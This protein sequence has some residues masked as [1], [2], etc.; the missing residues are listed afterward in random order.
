MRSRAGMSRIEVLVAILLVAMASGLVLAAIG[1]VR[2]ASAQMSCRNK[3]RQLGIAVANAHDVKNRLPSLVDQGEAAETGKGLP[4]MF[5]IITPYLEQHPWNYYPGRTATEYYANSSVAFGYHNKDGAPGTLHGGIANESRVAFVCPSDI[6]A[7]RLRDVQMTLPDGTTGYYATGSYAANGLLR[8]GS[9][10]LSEM[11]GGIANTIMLAERPQVCTTASGETVYN[12]WGVGFYSPHMPAFATLTPTDPP[13]LWPTGQ[14]APAWPLP[15]EQA[16][17]GDNH[18][19]YRI[20]VRDAAVQSLEIAPFQ[21]LGKGQPC[22]PRLPGTM[23]KGGMVVAMADGS[24]RVFA[25]DTSQWVFWSVCT[26][27]RAAAGK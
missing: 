3:F 4:S 23:H 20:G 18:I 11:P 27:E 9:G 8:W 19:Q 7:H 2:E 1:Q 12:L 17:D 5:A 14:I 15:H 10:K 25:P 24:V 16:N 22:D 6:T 26:W 21:M 13:G